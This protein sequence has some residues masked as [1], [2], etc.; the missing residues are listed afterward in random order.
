M[1]CKNCDNE[2]KNGFIKSNNLYSNEA[3]ELINNELGLEAETYC[4]ACGGELLK[5]AKISLEE[6]NNQIKKNRMLSEKEENERINQIA[7]FKNELTSDDYNLKQKLN[8]II[9][10]LPVLTT[11][12]PYGWEYT[13]IG[14]VSGQTVTG[15][16]LVSEVLSDFTD[17]FGAKSGSFTEKLEK[18]EEFVLNQLRAKAITL[19]ANA[20]IATDIDYG[21]AGGAKGMLMVCAAGTAIKLKNIEI[22][23]DKKDIV[24]KI[25]SLRNELNSIKDVL[26]EDN[27][28]FVDKYNHHIKIYKN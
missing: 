28:S 4:D 25:T 12:T 26:T 23:E 16:G 6:K 13:S 9:N 20:I 22:L 27:S 19:G 5:K 17:F 24:E 11:H 14:L 10:H 3:V 2:I 8:K 18:S 21:E 1:N 7:K 15:T